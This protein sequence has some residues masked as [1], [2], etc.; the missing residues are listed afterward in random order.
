MIIRSKAPLRLGLA[1]GGTDLSSYCDVYGGFTLNS[2]I[3]L[4]VHCTLEE[5][6]DG[7]VIFDS[8][9]THNTLK[10]KSAPNFKLDGNMDLYKAIYNK[11]VREYVKKPLSLSIYTFSDVPVGSGLGGSSTL[12]IAI[13]KA[14]VEWLHLPLS[15]YD[16]ARLSFEIER[17]DVGIV[18]GAQD[19]YAAAFGGFNAI[20][21]DAN[22]VT[23]SPVQISSVKQKLLE[24]SW[25][26]FYTGINRYADPLLEE[27]VKK[28]AEKKNDS[29]LRTMVEMSNQALSII[30]NSSDSEFIPELGAFLHDGWEIKKELSSK[31]S[32]DIIDSLYEKARRAGAIGG[33]LSGAGAGGF[34]SFFVPIEKQ[35]DVRK[36]LAGLEELPVAIAEDGSSIIHMETQA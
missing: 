3:S 14:F 13:V 26:M 20:N 7:L 23:V 22:G 34:L 11:I 15:E 24:D 31:I 30:K 4:Y 2:T 19:Q 17:E 5:R 6:S 1:G 35:K 25:L 21:F 8:V 27:Q 18:G 36:A 9:D 12:V 16:I 33:K 32:N 10:L 28:T 29:N